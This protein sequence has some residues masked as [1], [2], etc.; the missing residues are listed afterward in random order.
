M[1]CNVNW[2]DIM[3]VLSRQPQQLTAVSTVVQSSPE[4]TVSQCP[5]SLTAFMNPYSEELSE[6]WEQGCYMDVLFVAEWLSSP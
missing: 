5:L 4:V 6:S 3:Q 1:H 2:F